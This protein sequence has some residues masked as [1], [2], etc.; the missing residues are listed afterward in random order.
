MLGAIVLA[1][2]AVMFLRYTIEHDLIPPIVRVAIGVIVGLA[3]IAASEALRKRDYTTTANALAGGGIVVL[4]VSTWSA[5]VLYELIATG[6]AYGLM[7]LITVTCGLLSWR[8]RARVTAVLGLVGGFATPILL[9]TGSDN[10][11]GLF[12]YVLL[13]DL[14]LLTLARRRGW[15]GLM[16]LTL[17]GTVF[18][19]AAWIFMR[20][21]PERTVLGLGIL[22]VFGVFFALTGRLRPADDDDPRQAQSQRLTQLAGLLLPV[23]FAFYFAGNADLGPHLYPVAALLLLLLAA[24]CWMGRVQELP[25]LPTAAAAGTAGVVAVW[26]MRTRFDDALAWEATVVCFVLALAPHLFFEYDVRVGEHETPSVSVW[27]AWITSLG[28]LSLLIL[29]C[30]DPPS[31][32]LW[33]WLCG[34][35]ALAGLG[36]RQATRTGHR[37]IQALIAGALGVGLSIFFLDHRRTSA[38]P[39]PELYFAIVVLVAVGFQTL[40]LW[41]RELK[42]KLAADIAAATLPLTLLAFL[43]AESGDPHLTPLLFLVASFVLAFLA[44]LSATRMASGGVYFAVV[45]LLAFDHWL[46]TISYPWTGN[47]EPAALLAFLLQLV[48]V[49]VFSFWPLLAGTVFREKR[50]AWYAAALAAPVWFVALRAL[51]EIRFGDA[52][53]GLLPVAL[54]A[55][56]LAAAYQVRALGLPGDPARLRGLVWFSAVALGFLSV[57]IPLQ[58]EKQWIT[59]GW[60][61]QGVAVIALWKRLDHPGLKYFGLALLAAVTVRLVA[62]P[63]ILDYYPRSG[64]PIV[65]WLMYTYLVPAAA[66]LGASSILRGLEVARRREWESIYA[67]G[68]PVGAVACALGAILVVFAWINLTIFDFYSAGDRLTVSFERL[69]ARDLTLSLGWAVY[70]LLLLGIGFKRD[71]QG[72][73][74]ISLAFLVL[75]IGKVFL[76]DLGELEDLYRVASLVGLALSLI[77]VSLAYQR[78]VFRKREDE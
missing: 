62:N 38:F 32:S 77:L 49:I 17:A 55:V 50:W 40:A 1:L 15:P 66:L 47:P 4:Y 41:Q 51:F 27:P 73:R 59:L 57:A 75:T 18:Y 52:A 23:A 26:F 12:S 21:G 34:W 44:A 16:M 10:P 37:W 25:L 71:S 24:A 60:A 58:L 35:L 42:A 36:L 33:P 20:M 69:A 19:Q 9:S 8:H 76:Y 45:M 68:H 29:F 6:F 70:A 2:A 78:F 63:E 46:W 11:I 53:I 65:N 43:T 30:V 54:G 3:S 31:P 48:P 39:L 64:W 7:I 28:F 61:L 74:W 5:R 13:L 56:S 14:G 22:G 72:L 67:G